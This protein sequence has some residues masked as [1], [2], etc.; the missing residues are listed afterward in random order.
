MRF[1]LFF[2]YTVTSLFFLS[3]LP[4]IILFSCYIV[5][6]AYPLL[7]VFKCLGSSINR[8]LAYLLLL[9]P[10]LSDAFHFGTGIKKV[11]FSE[12]NREIIKYEKVGREKRE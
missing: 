5:V 4:F 10:D 8:S 11:V 12:L 7:L 3:F 9:R 2:M 6:G 1:P